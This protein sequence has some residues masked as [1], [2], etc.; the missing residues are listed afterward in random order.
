MF[1]A[2]A[3]VYAVSLRN[4]VEM[5]SAL[6]NAKVPAELHVYASGGHGFG[7]R[8]A[9]HSCTTWP[10]R[11]EEWLRRPENPHPSYRA[12]IIDQ[13]GILNRATLLCERQPGSLVSSAGWCEHELAGRLVAHL[14]NQWR[15][16]SLKQRQRRILETSLA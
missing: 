8:A 2:H 10:K 1:L 6:K 3:R 14:P 11:C 13:P 7:L 9:E 5:Y 16:F 4:S 12:A 15:P